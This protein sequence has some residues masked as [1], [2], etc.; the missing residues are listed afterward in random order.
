[1]H[2]VA[3]TW[4]SLSGWNLNVWDCL[5]AEVQ[6]ILKEFSGFLFL[7]ELKTGFLRFIDFL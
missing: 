1:V 3:R 7:D 5:T 2:G 6:D 4:I